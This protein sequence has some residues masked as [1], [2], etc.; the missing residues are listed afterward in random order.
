VRA[1][2]KLG[3]YWEAY[4]TNPSCELMKLTLTV[5][6]EYEEPGFWQR[7]AQALRLVKEVRPVSISVTDVSARGVTTSPR[8]VV[9]DVSTLKPG[10][11]TVELDIEVA[12]QYVVHAERVIEIVP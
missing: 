7:R 3:F 1:T 11:H 9:V 4:G 10:K 12:G 8:S 5:A 2:Q 6:P